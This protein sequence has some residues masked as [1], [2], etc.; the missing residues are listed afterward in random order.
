MTIPIGKASQISETM[1]W[2]NCPISRISQFFWV[3]LHF[4]TVR[5]RWGILEWGLLHVITRSIV[6]M[7]Y[8][9]SFTKLHSQKKEMQ[10]SNFLMGWN[11]VIL[12][13]LKQLSIARELWT[14][15]EWFFLHIVTRSRGK[16]K[17]TSTSI[18]L[19]SSPKEM[20]L[21]PRCISFETECMGTF[22]WS[23]YIY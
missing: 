15:L 20:Q 1:S 3:D 16:M 10:L 22:A 4:K 19:H 8:E 21:I 7:M 23:G 14:I 11:F 18:Y 17:Y 2:E 12:H 9:T 5:K 6:E 13:V